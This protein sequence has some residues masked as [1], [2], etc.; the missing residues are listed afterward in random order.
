MLQQQQAR[1]GRRGS[2][3]Q[4]CRRDPFPGARFHRHLPQGRI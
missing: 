3:Q 2:A 1:D 4:E